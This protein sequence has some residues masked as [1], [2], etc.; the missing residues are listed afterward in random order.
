[1][2][3]LKIVVNDQVQMNGDLGTWSSEPPFISQ[4]KLAIATKRDEP[5][6][7]AVLS[8]VAKAATGTPIHTINITTRDDGWTLDVLTDP[9]PDS[10][11]SDTETPNPVS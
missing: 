9:P 10:G 6:S 8:L 3:N 11:H 1:M 7:V 4:Q 5:W 2:P